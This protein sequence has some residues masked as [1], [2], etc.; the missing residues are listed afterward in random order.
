MLKSTKTECPALPAY[1]PFRRMSG[2]QRRA[3][4]IDSPQRAVSHSLYRGLRIRW[5]HFMRLLTE[6]S[7]RGEARISEPF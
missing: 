7:Q 6:G 3:K 5:R 1:S 4:A 2:S